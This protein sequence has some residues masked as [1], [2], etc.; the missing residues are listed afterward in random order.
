MCNGSTASP[1]VGDGLWLHCFP[2]EGVGN[3]STASPRWGWA[4]APLLPQGRGWAEA[5]GLVSPPPYVLGGCMERPTVCIFGRASPQKEG[6]TACIPGLVARRL[7]A[8]LLCWRVIWV[9]ECR[10]REKGKGR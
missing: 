5:I 3:G 10:G 9:S 2:K 7:A 1:K 8:V 6:C 4:M